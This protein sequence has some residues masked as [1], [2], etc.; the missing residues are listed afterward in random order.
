MMTLRVRTIALTALLTL[1]TAAS[2]TACGPGSPTPSGSGTPAGSPTASPSTDPG[3]AVGAEPASRF[4]LACEDL[5]PASALAAAH[6]GAVS[7]VDPFAT[8]LSVTEGIPTAAVVLQLGG[9][10]CGWSNG[11]PMIVDHQVNPAFAGT[12]VH[13]IADAAAEWP[14]FTDIYGGGDSHLNC[15]STGTTVNCD[16]NELLAGSWIEVVS[17]GVNAAPGGSTADFAAAV[18]PL[19]D[20][21]RAAVGGAAIGAL[22]IEESPVPIPSDCAAVLDGIQFGSALGIGTTVVGGPHGGWS[23]DASARNVAEASTCIYFYP[24]TDL[25]AGV[26]RWLPNAAWAADAGMALAT[27]P[28]L[29]TDAGLVGAADSWVRCAPSNG[30][31]TVDATVNGHWVQVTVYADDTMALPAPADRRAAALGAM[32]TVLTAIGT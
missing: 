32:E 30:Q 10:A 9:V 23:L 16:L 15:Y 14:K 18:T 12:T 11:A 22:E 29:P 13:V 28:A 24:D 20:A 4:D 7:A 27:F 21:V 25:A 3:P 1:T 19:L 2:L 6:A 31:C 8:T 17:Y 5:V 26:L